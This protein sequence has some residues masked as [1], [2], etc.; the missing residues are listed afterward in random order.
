[1]K[2]WIMNENDADLNLMAKVLKIDTQLANILANRNIRTKNTAIKFL[3]PNPKFLCDTNLMLGIDKAF[4]ILDEAIANKIKI[5]IYGDYDVDGVMST[6]ILFKTLS[7]LGACVDF[8]LPLRSDDGFGLNINAIDKLHKNGTK[9]I[10]TCDNGIAAI[11]E[12]EY[13]KSLGMKIIV[14]DHHEPNVENN[15]EILPIADAIIDNKQ[16]NCKYPFKFLCAGAMAYKFSVLLLEKYNLPQ[17]KNLLVFAALATLCDVVPLVDENRIIAKCGLDLINNND[18]SNKGLFALLKQ[19]KISDR[20]INSTDVGFIIG[21]CINACGRLKSADLAA[22][23]FLTEDDDEANQ[24]AFEICQLN[25]QRKLM[26]RIAYD[27]VLFELSDYDLI[28]NPV[29]VYYNKNVD[30]SIAGI[31][32]GKI[33]EHFYH[34]VIFFTDSNNII[35]GSARSIE[36]Y[37]IFDQLQKCRN[38]FLKFGGHPM[39]AG[40]SMEKSNLKLLAKK[41]NENCVLTMDDFTAKIK[42]DSELNFRQINFDL[43]NKI[44]L[45]EPFGHCNREPLFLS[46]NVH[47]EKINVIEDKNT[48]IFTLSQNNRSL[49]AICFG[50]VDYFKEQ[51]ALIYDNYECVKILNGSTEHIDL[52]LDI[53]YSTE[54]NEFNNKTSIELRLKDFIVTE[55]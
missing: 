15:E 36:N 52:F 24:L 13:A 1:M 38:L 9:I 53:V 44:S 6:V 17:D 12:I 4:Q 50:L 31:V 35:K 51:L 28:N 3:N 5:T 29:I 16:C 23:L 39:A 30:E 7:S 27:E 49:K 10:F 54:V 14:L 26:T 19:N 21:P 41:L 45:L 47:V 48:I 32:A 2:Q 37:N 25:E 46:K 40:I 33:K 11:N 42:I 55:Q 8:Y 18:F 43:I 20:H 22:K 34:P